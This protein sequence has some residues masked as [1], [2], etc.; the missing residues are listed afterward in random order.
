VSTGGRGPRLRTVVVVTA[1]VLVASLLLVR[2]RDSLQHGNRLFRHGDAAAAA[3]VYE[4]SARGGRNGRALYNLGTALL[5]IDVDSAETVLAT[6]A[7]SRERGTAERALYNLGYRFL[8]AADANPDSAFV[9]LT[10][11][12]ASNRAAL[13]LDPSDSDARWNLALAQRR[14]DALAPPGGERGEESRDD[15]SDQ[16]LSTERS[17]VQSD[18]PPDQ[19]GPVPQNP[20]PADARGERTGPRKGS[21]E[22]WAEQDPGPL[23]RAQA[24]SLLESVNDDPATLVRGIMW[25]RRPDVAWWSGQA[26]PGGRW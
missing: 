10:Q 5:A 3:A 18:K 12:V 24:L 14:L 13:R 20:E 9:T 25:S 23:T 1:A 11:A 7:G 15:A 17:L 6:A 4:G 8:L 26:S 2:D 21:T 19:Q 16:P 22:T